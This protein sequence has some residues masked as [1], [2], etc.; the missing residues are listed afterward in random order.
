MLTKKVIFLLIILTAAAEGFLFKKKGEAK[1]CY[2][3]YG[4]FHKHPGVKWG[5]ITVRPKLPQSPSDV[6][7][8]F[9]MFT[10]GGF[11]EVNDVDKG[12]LRVAKFDS[13]RQKTIFVIHG[14]REETGNWATRMKDA[15]KK[16]GDFNIIL[17]DWK[18]GADKDYFQAAGNTRLVGAQVAELIR[19]LISSAS[20]SPTS[21]EKFYIIG[22]SLG[23]HAA[24]YAGTYL[25]DNARM[26]LGRITGLDPAG[27]LFTNVRDARFR[28]DPSDARYVDV[29]HTDMPPKSGI[30]GFGMRKEAGHADFFPNGGV[31]QPGC[32]Q[33]LAKLDIFRTV[34]CDHMRAPEFYIK[35]VNQCSWRVHPCKSLEDCERG[36]YAICNSGCSSM[37]FRADKPK[38]TGRFYLKTTSNSPFC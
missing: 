30:F 35:S 23:A 25:K 26:T 3:K 18:K 27:P 7:T 9:T 16:R 22:F 34:I 15:L 20:G 28:L 13:R 5:L 14:W 32:R 21:P 19:F 10:R 38:R 31:K 29:I 6:G 33:S 11:G 24:G 37:G 4:C 36:N 8:K 1:K 17:V 2:G 12:G